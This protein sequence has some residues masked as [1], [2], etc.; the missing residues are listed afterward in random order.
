MWLELFIWTGFAIL[1]AGAS[2][3]EATAQAVREIQPT[4][5][6][7][8]TNRLEFW[9][10]AVGMVATALD[11]AMVVAMFLPVTV[12]MGILALGVAISTIVVMAFGNVARKWAR[13]HLDQLVLPLF[14]D[15]VPFLPLAEPRDDS[16]QAEVTRD[17]TVEQMVDASERVGLIESDERQM[18]SGILQL[19]QT[20]VRE[21]MVP[22]IDVIAIEVETSLYDALDVMIDGA[23][24]RVPVYE[25]TIDRIV[26]LLYAKDVLRLLR[27]GKTDTTLRELARPAYLVPESKRLD[28]LL[29][30]LQKNQVH[31]AIVVDEYGGTAGIVTIE[32]VLEE[33]VGEIQDEYDTGEPPLVERL[34]ENEGVFDARVNLDEV[35][36]ILGLT[37]PTDNNT[38]GGLIYQRLEKM[39]K[40]GDQVRVDDVTIAVLNVLGRRI[41]KVRVTKSFNE[42]V[43][44]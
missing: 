4:T 7:A 8:R 1:A 6:T 41:K 13:N 28:E 18:I 38:L 19:D 17:E 29:Q 25:E 31:M 26:G 37:L 44:P 24:S 39:P 43:E 9:G 2:V 33:I 40:V 22:R 27:D 11:G 3:V 12:D 42:Q 36:E 20:L 23:H 16:L 10:G 30:E 32:D 14:G 15:T 21:I 35:N 5:K 34:G